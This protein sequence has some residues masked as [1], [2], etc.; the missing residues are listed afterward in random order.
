MATVGIVLSCCRVIA[1]HTDKPVGVQTELFFA[2][3]KHIAEQEHFSYRIK[4]TNECLI[5]ILDDIVA[6]ARELYSYRYLQTAPC[7]CR[8]LDAVLT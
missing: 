5:E 7:Y 6:L 3:C 4:H 1:S 2:L 8:G